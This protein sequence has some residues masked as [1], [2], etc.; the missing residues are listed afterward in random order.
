MC[1]GAGAQK[2]ARSS[3]HKRK[4]DGHSAVWTY[5]VD[6]TGETSACGGHLL[7]ASFFTGEWRAKEVKRADSLKRK[8]EFRYTY[9]VGK[10]QSGR[11]MALVYAKSRMAS[12]RV[13]FSVSKKIG[14]S[15]VRNRV[16]R[17]MREA[18]TP[19]IQELQPG[20]Q[21]IFIAREQIVEAPFPAIGSAMETMLLRAGL[22]KKDARQ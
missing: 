14:N 15:V 16:K 6:D 10:S 4:S 7:A 17:R 2:A 1:S 19:L 9:R 21:M 12:P 20:Y 13:G 5:T 11:Y 3:A 8:K 22:I 18:V